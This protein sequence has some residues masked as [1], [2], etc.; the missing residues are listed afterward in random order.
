MITEWYDTQLKK[1]IQ[2]KYNYKVLKYKNMK[3]VSTFKTLIF[4][5]KT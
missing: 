2:T 1:S 3:N 4:V 5:I